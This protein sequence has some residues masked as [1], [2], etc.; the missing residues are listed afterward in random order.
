VVLRPQQW[1]KYRSKFTA[2]A[3]LGAADERKHQS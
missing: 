2:G 1:N 3:C